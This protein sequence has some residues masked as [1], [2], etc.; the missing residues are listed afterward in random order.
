MQT[1][2]L[3]YQFTVIVFLSVMLYMHIVA[4]KQ[5]MMSR[6]WVH[7]EKIW[8]LKLIAHFSKET[9]VLFTVILHSQISFQNLSIVCILGKKSFK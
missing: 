3:C 2:V 4:S 9:H 6:D 1:F 8:L 5:R 7:S